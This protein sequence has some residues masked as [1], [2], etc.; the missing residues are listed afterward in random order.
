MPEAIA[1]TSALIFLHQLGRIELLEAFYGRVLVPAAVV[2]EL[3]GG[4]PGS[5][6]PPL[7]RLPW[8]V[9][10]SVATTLVPPSDLG[11]GEVE[12]VALGLEHPGHI[13]I[14]DDARARAYARRFGLRVTGTLGVLARGV[15]EGSLARLAPELDR[16]E[17]LG[18]RMTQD[19]RRLLL[20]QVGE[21]A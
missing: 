12:V 10:Q 21:Q 4:A 2:A 3:A 9:S 20:E 1:D 7:E 19:L 17:S 15:R 5:P 14:L 6:A 13:L 16:L 8:I 11:T 18:F